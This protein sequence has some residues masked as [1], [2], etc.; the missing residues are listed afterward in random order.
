MYMISLNCKNEVFIKNKPISA[1][2]NKRIKFIIFNLKFKKMKIH[3]L[4]FLTICIFMLLSCDKGE[5]ATLPIIMDHT[6]IDLDKIPLE[7]I[8]KAKSDLHIAYGHTSHGSQLISG[9]NGLEEWKGS[10]YLW[11]NGPADE[12][13]DIR[14]MIMAGDLGSKGDLA[15][16]GA[17]RSFL[18]DFRNEDINVI[19]WSWCGGVSTNTEQGIK[20]YLDEMNKL[21]S[22]FPSVQFVYMTGHLDGTG[23]NGTLHKNNE[24]IRKYCRDNNKILYDF[25]D[26][27]SYDPDGNYYLDKGADDGCNYDSNGDGQNDSNWAINWQNTHTEGVDW[28]NCSS[29]HSKPLNANMKAY[30]AWSLWSRL[31][32]WSGK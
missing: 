25:A 30:A 16:A 17:T 27:E 14:D 23:L 31:A 32:G 21:E 19:I 20:A 12:S 18:G 3:V 4:S 8:N 7:W 29:A 13:L 2:D 28:F 10:P 9:M 26:I 1:L 24:Q 6:S 5:S 22:E 15:W 11:N